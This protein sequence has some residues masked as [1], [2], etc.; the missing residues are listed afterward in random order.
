MCVP[1]NAGNSD[2]N[3]ISNPL[4]PIRQV[5]ASVDA[6]NSKLAVVSN[7]HP[8]APS[9]PVPTTHADDPSAKSALATSFSGCHPYEKCRLDNSTHTT[10]TFAPASAR[11]TP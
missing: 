1:I 7:S 9:P 3:V 6:G 8:P 2:D 10:S 5:I 4:S 11:T